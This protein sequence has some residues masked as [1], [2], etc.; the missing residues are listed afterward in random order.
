MVRD[1][2]LIP[3]QLVTVL[4]ATASL[5]AGELVVVDLATAGHPSPVLARADGSVERID[6]S[7]PL[8]GLTSKPGYEYRRARLAPGDALLLYTDGLTD[9]RAPSRVL[10]DTGLAELLRRGSGLRGTELVEFLEATVTGEEDPRDDITMLVVEVPRDQKV[11][12]QGE[13]EQ[14]SRPER[15]SAALRFGRSGFAFLLRF[16]PD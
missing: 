6:V 11:A 5:H 2:P 15:S 7:G 8:V 14:S 3:D 12:S 9:A 4:F 16:R 13:L 1:P 10:D